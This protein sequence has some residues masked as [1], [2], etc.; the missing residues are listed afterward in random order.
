MMR[1]EVLAEVLYRAY[2]ESADPIKVTSVRSPSWWQIGYEGRTRWRAVADEAMKFC[3]V[4][5]KVS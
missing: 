4:S 5:E 1:S 2:A 3:E